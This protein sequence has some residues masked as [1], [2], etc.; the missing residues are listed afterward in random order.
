MTT[1]FTAPKSIPTLTCSALDTRVQVEPNY[2][3]F[4]RHQYDQMA[5]VI[6][7]YL[8]IYNNEIFCLKA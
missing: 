3:G 5:Q 8:A 2:L 4:I 7:Q 1:L 6:F